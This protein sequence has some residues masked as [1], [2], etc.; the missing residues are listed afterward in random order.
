MDENNRSDITDVSNLF[1][2][3]PNGQQVPL[4]QVASVDYEQGPVQVIREDG[5]RRITVGLNVRGRD[6]KSVVEEIQAKLDKSYK[7][8]VG[9]YVTYG[10]QFENL[11]EASKRLSVALPI[12]LGLIL[13]LL[14]FTFK[15]AKQALLIFSAIPLSAIGGVFALSLRG[16]PLAFLPELVLL[17]CS[18]LQF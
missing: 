17:L 11:I 1:I 6:I 9:Y 7:L 13:V 15:S 4:S 2:P 3:L 18:E 8:P 16:M 10:G 5:K 14:Y 12:A